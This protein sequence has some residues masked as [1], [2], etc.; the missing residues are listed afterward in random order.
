MLDI[1]NSTLFMLMSVDGKISTGSTDELD[2]DKDLKLIDGVKEGLHQYYEIE[3][4]TDLWS[5]NTGRVMQKIGINEKTEIPNKI[6]VSFVLI[7]NKQHINENGL[8]YL[9]NWLDRV[10]I[11]TTKKD[12]IKI[13]DNIEIIYFEDIIDF[14]ALFKLLKS[15]YNIEDLTVQSGGTLNC[16][17]IRSNLIKKVRIIVAPI[18]IGGKDTATLVDGMSLTSNSELSKLKALKLIKCNALENSYLELLYEVIN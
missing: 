2:V 1:P 14:V 13:G 15:K 9:S 7:D 12:Y 6:P 3:Q 16:E 5:L 11:V 10:I 17:L 4:T 8:K 18:I